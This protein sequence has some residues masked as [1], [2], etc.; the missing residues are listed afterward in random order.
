MFQQTRFLLAAAIAIAPLNMAKAVQNQGNY[1]PP[2][3]SYADLADLS[4]PAPVVIDAVIKSATRMKGP[5]AATVKQG[6]LRYYVEA[7]VQRLI[8][9]PTGLAT[10]QAYVV[11]VPLDAMGRAPK[12]KKM[13]VLVFARPVP[14]RPGILQLVAG[15]SQINWSEERDRVVRSI[16]TEAVRSGAAPALAGISRG[17][18]V[19]GT[20]PGHSDSQIFIDTATGVPISLNVRRRPGQ[21]A[22][23]GIALGDTVGSE[24]LAAPR[25]DT[26]LW[27][28]L[29]C[30]LPASLPSDVASGDD[31]E[32][33][34][35][36]Y[37]L[38]RSSLG[39]CIRTR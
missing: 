3:L 4:I 20:L 26:L 16:L 15:D 11:D 28:R 23:W 10:R 6:H 27:Y 36:D 21:I 38:I 29:A 5:E 2:S 37:R 18:Y 25:Q 33:L 35:E 39:E 12:L 22:R 9:G 1:S 19:R 31:G 30:E 13:R 8:R 34:A 24:S 17:F 32:S 14:G 7:D